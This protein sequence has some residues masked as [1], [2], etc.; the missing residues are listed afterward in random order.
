MFRW[1]STSTELLEWLSGFVFV[2]FFFALP[3]PPPPPF[4]FFFLF[5]F[6]AKIDYQVGTSG[7][8]K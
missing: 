5:F 2:F 7:R 8:E 1:I 4:I 6:F 3:N